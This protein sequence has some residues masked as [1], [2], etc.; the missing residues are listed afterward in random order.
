MAHANFKR[1][2]LRN[3]G[4]KGGVAHGSRFRRKR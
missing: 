3:S 1:L 2:K 4:S